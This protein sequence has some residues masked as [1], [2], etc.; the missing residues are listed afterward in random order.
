M[1]EAAFMDITVDLERQLL[2]GSLLN[3]A[4]VGAGGRPGGVQIPTASTAMTANAIRCDCIGESGSMTAP[5]VYTLHSMSSH[6]SDQMRDSLSSKQ[7]SGLCEVQ[8]R[9]TGIHANA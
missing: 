7:P 1:L 2:A 5:P 4:L 9:S 6:K 3:E 8:T